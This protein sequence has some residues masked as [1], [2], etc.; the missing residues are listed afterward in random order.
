LRII[1]ILLILH[2]SLSLA[3]KPLILNES[4]LNLL[5]GNNEFN[6][7]TIN[8]SLSS[9]QVVQGTGYTENEPYPIIKV[10]LNEE[11]LLTINSADDEIFSII[12]N[13]N[14]VSSHTTHKIGDLF[15]DIYKT[16]DYSCNVGYEEW[17]GYAMCLAPKSAHIYYVFQKTNRSD[18]ELPTIEQLNPEKIEAIFWS[19]G[20]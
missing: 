13:S 10:S 9:Y 6:F 1:V 5:N 12:T 8:K 18:G 11:L 4:G 20:Y 3:Q 14:Q 16:G 15:K 19:R 17:S 7:K 2:S